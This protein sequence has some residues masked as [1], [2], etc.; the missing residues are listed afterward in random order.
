MAAAVDE[1][2]TNQM[3][4]ITV[5]WNAYSTF[6]IPESVKLMSPEDNAAVNYGDC[7]GSWTIKHNTLYYI[8]HKEGENF[9]H[10]SEPEVDTKRPSEDSPAEFSEPV[11]KADTECFYCREEAFGT[12]GSDEDRLLPMCFN[13]SRM[14]GYGD[15]DEE[16]KEEGKEE[17][18]KELC[19]VD[20]EVYVVLPDKTCRK[21][22]PEELKEHNDKWWAF[23][24][25]RRKAIGVPCYA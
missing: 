16:E 22:T 8:D 13:H 21:P 19:V 12:Y 3:P 7:L 23:D 9:I 15:T 20:G 25:A 14:K 24:I 18:K 17:T 5:T 11:M 1:Q 4:T 2:Y 10:G 6:E